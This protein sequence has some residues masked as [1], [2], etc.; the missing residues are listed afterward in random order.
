MAKTR[1]IAKTAAGLSANARRRLSRAALT[2]IPE[3]ASSATTDAALATVTFT[4]NNPLVIVGLRITGV[5]PLT[6]INS[7]S[8]RL[9]PGTRTM[10]WKAVSSPSGQPFRVTVAGATLDVPI[11]SVTGPNSGGVRQ[12]TV[13]AP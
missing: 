12:L 9:P 6:V 2:S 3:I 4:V 1:K 7:Q 10:G 8:I 13:G 5:P 11:Q